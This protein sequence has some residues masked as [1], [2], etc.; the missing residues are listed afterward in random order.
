MRSR[1]WYQLCPFALMTSTAHL[2][3]ALLETANGNE[4]TPSCLIIN[5]ALVWQ[6]T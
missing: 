6:E 4:P 3:P 2:K 1:S 5:K